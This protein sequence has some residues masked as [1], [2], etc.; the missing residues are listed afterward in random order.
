MFM[1]VVCKGHVVPCY[2]CV[3]RQV[4]EKQRRAV[5]SVSY[6]DFSQLEMAKYCRV[7]ITTAG[8][9]KL[10]FSFSF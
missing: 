1:L 9:R 2:A 4:V 8:F 5:S 3:P 10:R 7:Q 6:A